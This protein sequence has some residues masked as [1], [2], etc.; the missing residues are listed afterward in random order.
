MSNIVARISGLTVGFGDKRA[1]DGVDLQIRAGEIVALVGESGSGKTVLGS[2][3]L[4]IPPA[5]AQIGGTIDIDGVDMLHGPEKARHHVRRHRLGAVFQD[6]LTSL[7]PTMKAGAQVC[8]RGASDERGVAVMA[9]CGVPEP[10]ARFHYWPHQLSGGLRQRVSIAGAI[11]TDPEEAPALIVADEPTTALDVSVQ[12]TVVALFARLREQHGCSVLLITH[13]LGV[14]AQIADRIVVMSAGR[15]REQGPARKVLRSP[16]HPYTRQLLASRLDIAGP[17]GAAETSFAT[18]NPVLRLRNI[19]KDFPVPHHRRE[20][21]RVLH[22]VSLDLAEGESVALVGESGSGKSTLLRIAAGLEPATG[23]TIGS[24]A[25]ARP[26]LIFQDARA[27]LTP[28]MPVG[29]QIAER[30]ALAGVARSDRP[31]RVAELLEQ[32]G[33]DPAVARSRPRQMSGGQCQRAAIARALASSPRVLLC[34][35]PVSALDATLATQVV[36]LLDNLRRTTGVA[37][38][39]VTHDL[40]VA[41]RIAGRIAVMTEGRIVEEGEVRRVFEAPEHAYTKSLLAASPSLAAVS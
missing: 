37:L 19:T 26:Q 8:E 17:F 30:L 3:L 32:V 13:D 7:D 16:E 6:P 41:K 10:E 11:A 21:R 36:E 35:E 20:S 29:A 14:A 28:W 23:G 4:G 31:G 24:E 12:A 22:G 2:C 9:E 25:D 38:L 15:I 27:S 18:A 34:D 33:L 40:A 5:H 39:L 1:V